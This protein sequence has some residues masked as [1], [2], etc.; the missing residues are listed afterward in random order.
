MHG[1]LHSNIAASGAARLPIVATRAPQHNS[2]RTVAGAVFFAMD[3]NADT[4][5]NN[6]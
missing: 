1:R 3:G 4:E 2:P 5:T 6:S